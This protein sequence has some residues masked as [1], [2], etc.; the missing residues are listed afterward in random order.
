MIW[1]KLGMDS[2]VFDNV[3]QFYM[4]VCHI[5]NIGIIETYMQDIII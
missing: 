5:F 4:S 3:T 2:P 1:N